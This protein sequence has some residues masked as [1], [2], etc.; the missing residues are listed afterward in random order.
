MILEEYDLNLK[1]IKKLS[2]KGRLLSS[3]KVD[4][5]TKEQINEAKKYIKS[6][7]GNNYIETNYARNALMIFNIPNLNIPKLIN[8]LKSN[9]RI[10]I[11]SYIG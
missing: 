8:A 1:E 6:L 2:R 10:C 11:N 5:P 3:S 9:K 7:S 4:L